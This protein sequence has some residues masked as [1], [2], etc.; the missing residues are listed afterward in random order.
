MDKKFFT[1]LTF[2]AL[3]VVL[4]LLV[5][6][7][8]QDIKTFE[9]YEELEKFIKSNSVG[10][11]IYPPR[12]F[13]QELTAKAETDYS[14]TNIQVE[15]VDEADIVKND[16]EYIYAINRNNVLI[17]KAYPV[18][19]MKALSQIEM[20]DTPTQIFIDHDKLIVFGYKNYE[21]ITIP[22]FPIFYNPRSFVKVY[23]ISKKD[24]PKL[25]KDIVISGSYVQ[26]R[27]IDNYVYAVFSQ[28]IYY[29]PVR[30]IEMPTISVDG[31]IKNVEAKQ[32]YYFDYPDS[33][34]SFTTILSLDLNN[35]NYE[36]KTFLIGST[37]IIYASKENL[38]L[39]FTK[40]YNIYD[41]YDDFLNKVI[42]PS[43]PQ[44]LRE[45]INDAMSR[46]ISKNEKIALTQKII[47]DY[48]IDNPDQLNEFYEKVNENYA[49]YEKEISKEREKTIINKFSLN[50][51]NI[52]LKAKAEVPGHIL[53]QFS[54]DEYN[55]KFRI[56]T[57]SGFT[58]EENNVYVF[59]QNMNIVSKLEGIATSERIYS[60]RF[61]G[62]KLYLV[63][64][65]QIDPFFVIDLSDQPKVLGYLKI[66]GVSD[67]IHP[68]DETHLIG[69]GREV[70]EQ[71]RV[72]GLKIS[73]FDVSDFAFPKELYS[74]KFGE[75]GSY[76]EA[77][78]EHKAFLFSKE[79]NLLVIPATISDGTRFYP[80][81]GAV[82]FN[83]SLENG[84][85][86]KGKIDHG[87]QQ[88]WSNQI[89]RSL[90]IDDV[91]YT[92]SDYMIKANSLNDLSELAKI[93]FEERIIPL[94]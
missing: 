80:W 27:L 68:Y 24:E 13:A 42:I 33:S 8:K 7:K 2:V 92:V 71:G 31:N 14:K 22:E 52:E 35:M 39:T 23:D 72:K 88:F 54:M 21:Y 48:L 30:P 70:D 9:S 10:T 74:Y 40:Y 45:K 78:Y 64:F 18:E 53:N 41:F 12:L 46:D 89:K 25:I 37:Q 83:V 79:K 86:L 65:K 51:L 75:A 29:H 28:Q 67:Y 73:L 91:L 93:N 66:P 26:S 15:G 62:D 61:I 20:R 32:I 16:G 69:F 5:Q 55:G 90:Y 3:I 43:S 63:T 36:T 59:D 76:S 58:E 77:N 34:Y 60:S 87:K 44:E 56:A 50:G 17:V 38:Y 1:A 47:E 6:P 81:Q 94:K 49:I 19:E 4:T 11:S 82:V 85:S 84:I 57:T